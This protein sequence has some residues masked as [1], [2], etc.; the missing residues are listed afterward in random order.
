MFVVSV[1][2]NSVA[3]TG[4]LCSISVDRSPWPT[5]TAAMPTVT[6]EYHTLVALY[7][8]SPVT[9]LM[10]T[11]H[12][13]YSVLSLCVLR[14]THACQSISQML[15]TSSHACHSISHMPVN[16]SHTCLSLH[17]THTRLSLRLTHAYHS[18]S[19]MPVTLCHTGL[20]L[21]VTQACHSVSHRPI[22]LCHT[23]LSLCQS[24]G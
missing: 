12:S 14:V 6:C 21:C 24:A 2:L 8:T 16:P 15:V 9:H 18:V 5:G 13:V 22:T 23:G 4:L 10:L 20:S 19:H 7:C 3:V 17:L 1:W 11:R